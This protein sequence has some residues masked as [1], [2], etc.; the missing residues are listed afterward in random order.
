MPINEPAPGKRTSQIQVPL[1]AHSSRVSLFL[2]LCNLQQHFSVLRVRPHR[3]TWT[4]TADRACSTSPST[5][6][7]SL[8]LWGS[9]L[10]TR[11]SHLHFP[12]LQVKASTLLFIFETDREP[13][14]PRDG[15]P[16]STWRVLP[17]PA[18]ETQDG[19]DQGEGGPRCL[20][21][22]HGRKKTPPKKV[23]SFFLLI[24][25]FLKLVFLFQKLRILVDFDDKGYL[26]QIFTKPMQDRPTLFLEV[27][28]RYNHFVSGP[29]DNLCAF[30]MGFT[31]L[32]SYFSPSPPLRR[33][34]RTPVQSSH[35][36]R[37][38]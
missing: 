21:G 30:E 32:R 28:Q 25:S 5:R 23:F 3:N 33:R 20:T 17:G 27:I 29:E 6:Q 31:G 11:C 37:T 9:W 38:V 34:A 24:F 2:G 18:A 10:Q 36:G 7:T 1:A 14:R 26:L 15:V 22:E 13:A 35:P 19:Q 12:H 8:K 4:T 16:L